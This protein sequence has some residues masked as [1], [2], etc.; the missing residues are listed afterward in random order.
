VGGYRTVSDAFFLVAFSLAKITSS[1]G[2]RWDISWTAVARVAAASAAIV[3][4]WTLFD[5]GRRS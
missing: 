1:H 4:L 2:S 5:F 3:S